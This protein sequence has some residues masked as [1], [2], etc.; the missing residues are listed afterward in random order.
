MN[1]TYIAEDEYEVIEYMKQGY[2][3]SIDMLLESLKITK[4]QFYDH[5]YSNVS[6][7][8]VPAELR[9]RIK[10]LDIENEYLILFVNRL[11]NTEN[12]VLFNFDEVLIY[13][14]EAGYFSVELYDTEAKKYRNMTE[15]YV[16]RPTEKEL[17]DMSGLI[18]Q[19]LVH[20]EKSIDYSTD[21]INNGK[22]P[23]TNKKTL[24]SRF[25]S[26]IRQYSHFRFKILGVYTYSI[27]EKIGQGVP[28]YLKSKDENLEIVNDFLKNM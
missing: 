15:E 17:S 27:I 8:K 9:N 16:V 1:I 10:L 12:S 19:A 6:K 4:T 14:V 7:M 20:A 22:P 28:Q 2:L 21:F 24:Q 18:L 11:L 13:M 5:V 3:F 25:R 26:R 23:T